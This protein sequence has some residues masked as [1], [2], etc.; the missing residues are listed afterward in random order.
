MKTKDKRRN[1]DKLSVLSYL[2]T[3]IQT[4]LILIFKEKCKTNILTFKGINNF[5]IF[6]KLDNMQLLI[7]SQKALLDKRLTNFI[8]F[9]LSEE[10]C[11]LRL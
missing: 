10:L 2:L 7:L 11:K 5:A 9:R 6:K 1:I 4:T 3:Q 8:K